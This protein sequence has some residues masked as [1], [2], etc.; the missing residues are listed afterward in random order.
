MSADLF[1]VRDVDAAARS[2]QSSLVIASIVV[3]AVAFGA[4]V[5]V[6]ILLP[7]VLPAPHSSALAWDAGPQMVRLTDIP[8]PPPPPAKRPDVAPVPVSANAAPL[9]A[10]TGISD[11]PPTA[12]TPAPEE[13]G[14]ATGLV[15]GDLTGAAVAPP[16]PPPPVAVREPVRLHSG[17]DAPRK[18]SDAAPVYP[19]LAQAVAAQGIVIIE[20]TIDTNGDV[21]STKVLRSIPLLD[22]AALD[23]VR[24]WKYTPARLNG[25]PV[26][27]VITV[28]V[29]FTLA[30]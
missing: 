13:P 6:S 22:A 27:V 17:I 14:I 9:V 18:I 7:G 21:T 8:L 1:V 4:L 29:N 10:P 3:H 5:V 26:A 25:E 16:P 28:T 11:E 19:P 24:R 20:A 2:R 30:R 15:Q 23:A 12:G